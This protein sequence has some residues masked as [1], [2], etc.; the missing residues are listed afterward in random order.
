LNKLVKLKCESIFVYGNGAVFFLW[1]TTE[2]YRGAF[3]YFCCSTPSIIGVLGAQPLGEGVADDT[4]KRKE[5]ALL[6]VTILEATRGRS[7]GN[8]A[9]NA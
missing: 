9:T 6:A 4:T 8:S 5:P 2:N 3:F 1:C 7:E